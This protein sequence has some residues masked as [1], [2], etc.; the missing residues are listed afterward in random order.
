LKYFDQSQLLEFRKVSTKMADEL[1]PRCFKEFVYDCPEEEDEE[2]YKFLE[3]IR[4]PKKVVIKNICGTESHLK[5]LIAIGERLL[6]Q[7]EYL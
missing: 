6:G 4:N 3:H 7:N 5:R 1:V 2:D